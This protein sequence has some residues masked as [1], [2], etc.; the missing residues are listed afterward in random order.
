MDGP[1]PT[2]QIDRLAEEGTAF[3]QFYTADPMC[4]P[5][6]AALLTGR[7]PHALEDVQGRQYFLN[8]RLLDVTETT[9]ARTLSS[10]GYRCAY[11]GKWHNDD[12]AHGEYIP[13]G[14]RRQGFSDFW[15]GVNGGCDRLDPYYFT[16]KGEKKDSNQDWASDLQV[17]LSREYLNRA[18]GIDD[19]FCLVVSITAPHGPL[20]L[21]DSHDGLLK[22][23]ERRIKDVPENVPERLRDEALAQSRAYHANVMGV[24]RCVGEIMECLENTGLSENTA[25][26]F[27]SDHGDHVYS[28]GL[29]GKNQF[30]EE[31]AAIPAVFWGPDRIQPRGMTDEFANMVDVAPT[32]IGLSGVEI[33]ERMQGH[34]LASFLLGHEDQTPDSSSYV[35]INHPWWDFRFGQGPQ[36]NRRCIVTDRWKLVLL[37][38]DRGTGSVIPWQLFDR[39]EDPHELDNLV[40]RPG[41]QPEI[42]ELTE[43]MWEWM[44]RTSDPFFERCV[45]GL[46]Q[47]KI[48]ELRQSFME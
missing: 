42:V 48:D 26:V 40:E 37:E 30:Y 24:D 4:T 36:G 16:D 25:V 17:E 34:S 14:P 2:P 38:S 21:P 28:H 27:L 5:A 35:E 29:Q 20:E 45:E 11:V 15:A 18:A 23:A 43:Q 33:P 46:R 7:Y 6:R 9:F 19:P 1:V 12:N 39:K 13:P 10:A 44:V 47:E 32:L 8:N 3:S 41:Y 22:E 31:A